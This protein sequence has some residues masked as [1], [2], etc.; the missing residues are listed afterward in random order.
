LLTR[1][2]LDRNQSRNPSNHLV[3]LSVILALL[4]SLG[5]VSD[6]NEYNSLST[7]EQQEMHHVIGMEDVII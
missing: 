7:E 4:M 6:A 1:V 5:L 3:M 2:V